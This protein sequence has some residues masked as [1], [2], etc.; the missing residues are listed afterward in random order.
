MSL[1]REVVPAGPIPSEYVDRLR[2][3]IRRSEKHMPSEMWQ[4]VKGLLDPAALAIMATVTGAW[5][6]SHF[7]GVGE[8]ADVILLAAGGIALGA[9]AVGIGRD[10]L[11]FA[12]GLRSAKS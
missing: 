4:Q 6:V 12:R 3:A 9:S 11:A 2:E 1:E 8:I 10:V 7:F 5:A